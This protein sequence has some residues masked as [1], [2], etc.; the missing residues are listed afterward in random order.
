MVGEPQTFWDD[1]LTQ[2]RAEARRVLHKYVRSEHLL[3]ALLRI[4]DPALREELQRV[5][6]TYEAVAQQVSSLARP[7]CAADEKQT[8]SANAERIVQVAQGSDE[9][10]SRAL[11]RALVLRSPLVRKLLRGAGVPQA[12]L[13]EM[14]PELPDAE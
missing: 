8:L 5:G 6:M 14:R 10:A 12:Y 11:L 1:L 13:E 7:V 9:D 3:L 2:A 4:T